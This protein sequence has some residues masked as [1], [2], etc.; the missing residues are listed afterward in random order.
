MSLRIP[1][2]VEV[3][4]IRVEDVERVYLEVPTFFPK[5]PEAVGKPLVLI[6][7]SGKD[8]NDKVWVYVELNVCISRRED[9]FTSPIV[10]FFQERGFSVQEDTQISTP[11]YLEDHIKDWWERPDKGRLLPSL[12]FWWGKYLVVSG[13]DWY[14]VAEDLPELTERIISAAQSF[15]FPRDGAVA[16]LYR[17]GYIRSLHLQITF[18]HLYVHQ[19]AVFRVPTVLLLTSLKNYLEEAEEDNRY[20]R[21]PDFL[22]PSAISSI[23]TILFLLGKPTWGTDGWQTLL[24]RC[25]KSPEKVVVSRPYA[26]EISS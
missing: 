9:F 3:S 4:R 19:E 11:V 20:F 1:V 12:V 26:D 23:L 22:P 15:P 6:R 13:G 25:I 21:L 5:D 14:K 17:R 2:N 7:L 8:F 16:L 10:S 18:Y 24:A